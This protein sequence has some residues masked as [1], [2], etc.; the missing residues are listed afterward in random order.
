MN[1]VGA[2]G[3]AAHT[4]PAWVGQVLQYWF[5]VL[6]ENHWFDH[7]R[8]VDDQIRDRFLA[9]HER[10]AA[11]DGA[12]VTTPREVLAAVI[13]LDQF[14]RNIFRGTSRDYSADATALQLARRAIDQ[15]FDFDMTDAQKQFLYMPYQH[16]EDRQD[17]VRS[18]TL[19]EKLGNEN[20]LQYARA[21]KSII[22]R[23]GRFPHRNQ[24]LGRTSSAEEIASLNEPMSSF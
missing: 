13:V 19:F 2:P 4:E 16:S 5:E 21:H 7:D 23:F 1:R 18:L 17:Q 14:S 6:N 11:G 12:E 10:L 9:L 8:G 3:S 22:D 20:W 15:G 24:V